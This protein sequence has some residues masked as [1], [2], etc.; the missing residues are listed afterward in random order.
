MPFRMNRCRAILILTLML[1]A[2]HM[3]A[4]WP[5]RIRNVIIMIADGNG[6]G[7]TALAR[8]YKGVPLS[9]DSYTCGLVRT[10]CADTP[11]TDSA[12]AA[13]AMAT[14][15][16]S[17]DG[18]IGIL[19]DLATMPGVP[20]VPPGDA[21]RP[22]ATV[23]EAARMSGRSTGLVATSQ[24]QHATPAAFSSHGPSRSDYETLAEQQVYNG[25]DVVLGGGLKYLQPDQR[26]DGEDLSAELKRLGYDLVTDP[27]RLERS[28]AGRLWGLFA[29][30]ALA[31]DFDRNPDRQPSLE[32]MT[33]KALELL[34]RNP[35]GFFLLVEGSQVDWAAHANDPAGVISELL[36]FDRAV[37]AALE[38]ARQDG[39]TAVIITTDH[40]T[41]GLTMGNLA[42]SKTYDQKT[43]SEFM[44]PLRKVRRTASG[45]AAL[46][47][48][49]RGNLKQVMAEFYGID[50]L[51]DE[52]LAVLA[53]TPAKDFDQAAGPML[54][55]RAN[56]GWTSF[57]HTGEDVPLYLYIPGFN[58]ALGLIENTDIARF[59]SDLLQLDLAA[60]NESLFVPVTDLL[61]G[62]AALRIHPALAGW[63]TTINEGE[64]GASNP[65]L[66]LTLT[67]G[68]T[69][70]IPANK[71]HLASPAGELLHSY[72]GVNVHSGGNWFI[73]R[74]AIVWL[75]QEN[76]PPAA[77]KKR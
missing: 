28:S 40:G 52:E 54:S 11:I 58:Q 6:A 34:S 30:E 24:V 50:D 32:A 65:A 1:P 49:G 13:T 73:P 8:W 22:L 45:L 62:P 36:A 16:K 63:A 70:V 33:G 23:L 29:P 25:L 3:K 53:K 38:F 57:G 51:T 41:G 66:F 35:R 55:R 18:Y 76:S 31:C 64:T 20:P 43:L 59:T 15:F 48:D 10:Y 72:Q 2:M 14:G 7:G 47:D 74:A 60:A 75:Q 9:Y 44:A 19:P 12:P 77:G 71:N 39:H 67:N 37:A 68:R 26:K 61:A 27:D 5:P 17:H 42:T 21:K 4:G 69:V 46:L 56:L